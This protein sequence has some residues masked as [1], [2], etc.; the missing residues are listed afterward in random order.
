MAFNYF[1][2]PYFGVGDI[3]IIEES[4]DI[5]VD[6]DGLEI[7]VNVSEDEITVDIEVE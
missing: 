1:S 3:S 4:I 2:P 6:A 5:E 7:A